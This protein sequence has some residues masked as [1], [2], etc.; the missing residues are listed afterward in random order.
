MDNIET[1]HKPK[2]VDLKENKSM[3]PSEP[4]FFKK[5]ITGRPVEFLVGS[6]EEE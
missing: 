3:A 2:V 6:V 4:E 5:L 1:A